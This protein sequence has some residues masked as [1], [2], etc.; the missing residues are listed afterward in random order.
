MNIDYALLNQALYVVT[1]E[2]ADAL[3]TVPGEHLAEP[4]GMQAFLSHYMNMIKGRDLQV[5]AAYFA[6]SCR[7]LLTARLYFMTA[8]EGSP[9]L[10]LRNLTVEIRMANNYP[11]IFFVIG[12][13]AMKSW[14]AVQDDA[15]RQETA[16]LWLESTLRPVM[17][18][19]AKVSGLPVQQL[20]G[21]MP[22]GVEFYLDYLGKMTGGSSCHERLVEQMA[23]L[24]KD[25]HASRFGLSR[26]PFDLKAVWLDDP[27]RPG[28]KTR[29][30]PT[31]CL[32]YRTDSGHGYCYGCPKLTKAER[33]EKYHEITRAQAAR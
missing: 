12:D 7:T 13:L 10:S 26:N 14:P 32:A 27:Y 22:L 8:C 9:D 16:G 15:W 2:D 6:S 17:E 28:N 29:M 11:C 24:A 3:L 1:E 4:E 5:A 21:Q 23:F 25:V 18:A 19:A 20:W 30:K 33:A 31:C